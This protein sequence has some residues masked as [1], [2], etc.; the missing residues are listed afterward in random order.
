VVGGR[1]EEKNEEEEGEEEEW[2]L[3]IL[4]S[5]IFRQSLLLIARFAF[6]GCLYITSIIKGVTGW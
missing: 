2:C 3:A 4:A 5:C 6:F 1:G